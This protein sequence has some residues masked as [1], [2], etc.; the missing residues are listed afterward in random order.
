M[1][2]GISSTSPPAASDNT[3]EESSTDVELMHRIKQ[4][5][6]SALAELIDRWKT[7]LINFF[8]R[9][10]RSYETAEDLSQV[11]FV[12]IYRAAPKYQPTAKF[13][14]YLFHIARRLLINEFRRQQRKPLDTVDPS[15][16]RAVD[17]AQS[18]RE[19]NEIEEAFENALEELPENQ[20]TAILLLKQ[21]QLS[22]Q[23]IAAIMDATESAVKTWIFRARQYLKLA[24]KDV[25]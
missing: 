9:S 12:R 8:Y 22:Y 10:I 11:V 4:G 16:L 15:E 17:T 14:T 3:D 7:P 6:D 13:S 25:V 21:Q 1:S 20:R 5:D 2:N 18:M 23:E 24:L 19:I